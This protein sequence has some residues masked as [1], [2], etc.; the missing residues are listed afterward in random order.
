[1][2]DEHFRKL[3]P[4]EEESFRQWAREE[5]ARQGALGPF[6]APKSYWHPVVRD[7]WASLRGAK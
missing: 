6:T 1:M 4:A 3:T 2:R 5:F 7:E